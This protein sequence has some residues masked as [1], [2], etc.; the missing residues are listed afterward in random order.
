[1]ESAITA[2]TFPYFLMDK[3]RYNPL[4]YFR[5]GIIQEISFFFFNMENAAR[6]QNLCA[7]LCKNLKSRYMIL[8][9][10]KGE[11]LLKTFTEKFKALY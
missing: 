2:I 1:M 10:K 11:N 3:E 8:K 7:K 6:I 9:K 4:D 5:M